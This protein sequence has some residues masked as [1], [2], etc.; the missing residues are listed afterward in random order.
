VFCTNL[1]IGKGFGIT[2]INDTGVSDLFG[3][4]DISS[5]LVAEVF[6]LIVIAFLTQTSNFSYIWTFKNGALILHNNQNNKANPRSQ[7]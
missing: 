3:G 6:S 7:G 1:N 2:T 4:N 5:S